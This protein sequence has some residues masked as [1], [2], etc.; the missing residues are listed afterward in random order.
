MTLNE[1]NKKTRERGET[2]RSEVHSLTQLLC[3]G[4]LTPREVVQRLSHPH[5]GIW[6]DSTHCQ[7]GHE[8]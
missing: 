5:S 2:E 7:S 6:S 8:V 3:Q 1:T 4:L